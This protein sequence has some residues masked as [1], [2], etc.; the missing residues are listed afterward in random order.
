M[1]KTHLK[2]EHIDCKIIKTLLQ[3]LHN[4]FLYQFLLQDTGKQHSSLDKR[5]GISYQL[6][7]GNTRGSNTNPQKQ[8]HKHLEQRGGQPCTLYAGL[9]RLWGNTKA[10][11]LELCPSPAMVLQ[12]PHPQQELPSPQHLANHLLQKCQGQSRARPFV[13]GLAQ[14]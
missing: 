12:S 2:S 1:G 6:R 13:K 10:P 11:K 5:H 4:T 8:G 14:V 9:H 7:P 3:M